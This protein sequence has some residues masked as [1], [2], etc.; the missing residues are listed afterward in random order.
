MNMPDELMGIVRD[1]LMPTKRR[2]SFLLSFVLNDIELYKDIVLPED[3]YHIHEVIDY[4]NMRRVS[5][6][7]YINDE[8]NKYIEGSIRPF[9]DCSYFKRRRRTRY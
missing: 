7:R 1:Y 2:H 9:D 3:E 6:E 8:D 5:W 4:I